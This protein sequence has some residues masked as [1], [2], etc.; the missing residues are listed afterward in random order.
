[1]LAM[2]SAVPAAAQVPSPEDEPPPSLAERESDEASLELS[3]SR[4]YD[5]PE[6]VSFAWP[7]ATPSVAVNMQYNMT[8]DAVQKPGF[9]LWLGVNYYPWVDVF[10]TFWSAGI[11]IE[12]NPDVY[13]KP[14]DFVP[15]LRSGFAWLNGSPKRFKN[16]LLPNLQIYGLGGW[17]VSRDEDRDSRLRAGIGISSPRLSPATAFMLLYGVPLPNQL[18]F[19]VEAPPSDISQWDALIAVGIGL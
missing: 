7:D 14:I 9:G 3:P 2:M 13:G 11:K 8:S 4:R 6:P 12:N 17:R 10:N 19:W 1:M 18:E 15:T 5:R 16:Q